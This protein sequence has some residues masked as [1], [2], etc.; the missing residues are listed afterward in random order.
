MLYLGLEIGISVGQEISIIFF[1][2]EYVVVYLFDV[3]Q[4]G[5]FDFYVVSGGVEIIE[6]LGFL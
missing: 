6:Y 3:D 1:E 5:D 4:D 2:V